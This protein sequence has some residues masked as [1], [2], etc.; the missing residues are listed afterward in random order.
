MKDSLHIT[1]VIR[2][3]LTFSYQSPIITYDS[4]SGS[5]NCMIVL[6]YTTPMASWVKK[7]LIQAAIH[8]RG[9]VLPSRSRGA[10][11][12]RL[13]T[14]RLPIRPPWS[15]RTPMLCNPIAAQ[16]TLQTHPYGVLDHECFGH[17]PYM[18]HFCRTF[19]NLPVYGSL[20]PCARKLLLVITQPSES[21]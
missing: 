11:R 21:P 7:T 6:Q 12:S 8:E 14:A 9:P 19:T 10:P 13:D 16:Q 15:P 3:E 17:V 1:F 5:P 20:P 18:S 2:A 4:A